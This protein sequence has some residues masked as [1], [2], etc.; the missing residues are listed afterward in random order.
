MT[1][2]KMFTGV[3][4]I[5]ILLIA[6]SCSNSKNVGLSQPDDQR[7]ATGISVDSFEI[8]RYNA[9]GFEDASLNP[10]ID[11]YIEQVG[12]ETALVI[13]VDEQDVDRTIAL[14]VEFDGI[15]MHYSR[16]EFHGLLGGDD[17]V[18]GAS[19]GLTD[20]VQLGQTA[21]RDYDPG[22]ISG[23][24]ATIYFAPG[25]SRNTSAVIGDVYKS[26]T[27]VEVNRCGT[28]PNFV[29]DE[30]TEN[31][32][33]FTNAW[34]MAD[35]DQNGQ[36]TI[37]DITPIG[38]YLN[39]SCESNPLA[40]RADY[41]NNGTVTI[42]ELTPLGV[43][44]NEGVSGYRVGLR[45]DGSGST[46]L[47][48]EKTLDPSADAIAA[49]GTPAVADL[50][51]IF[52]H[53]NV[54]SIFTAGEISAADVNGTNGVEICVV[55]GNTNGDGTL[56]F[57]PWGG[58]D[59]PTGNEIVISSFDIQ[60][61]GVTGG[62]G[63]PDDIFDNG[64]AG[65]SVTANA[66][67]SFQLNSISGTF[68]GLAFTPT[69]LADGMTQGHYD[70]ALAAVRDNTAWTFGTAGA[71]GFRSTSEW[72]HDGAGGVIGGTGD[73]GAGTVFPDYDP[74]SDEFSPEGTLNTFLGNNASLANGTLGGNN[75]V[76]KVLSDRDYSWT[77]D[78]VRDPQQAT[79]G[80]I[81]KQGFDPQ[82]EY[83]L[84]IGTRSFFFT[85]D[86]GELGQPANFDSIEM[87]IYQVVGRNCTLVN[88]FSFTEGT[89]ATGE[90]GI[91]ENS[92]NPGEFVFEYVVNGANLQGSS[93]YVVRWFNGVAWTSINMPENKTI[94][95]GPAPAAADLTSIPNSGGYKGSDQTEFLQILYPNPK[96]RRWSDVVPNPETEA[97]DIEKGVDNDGF[98]VDKTLA[99]N[100]ILRTDGDEFAIFVTPIDSPQ[101]FKIWPQ[102][103]IKNFTAT[104]ETDV[105][106]ADIPFATPSGPVYWSEPGA[107]SAIILVQ[108]GLGRIVVDIKGLPTEG[109]DFSSINY[110][111][112][113]FS[114]QGSDF[115]EVG[116]GTFTMS[117]FD[118][119]V[120][121]NAINWGIDAFDRE[122]RD[123]DNG[124]WSNH[125]VNGNFVNDPVQP[126]VM[127]VEFNG[128]TVYDWVQ[129]E[130]KVH[131]VNTSLDNIYIQVKDVD[132]PADTRIMEVGLRLIGVTPTGTFL[133]I[134]T[135]TNRDFVKIP[136]PPPS[137]TWGILAPG[138]SYEVSI[139]DRVQGSD[140]F[141]TDAG[142]LLVVI[143]TNPNS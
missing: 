46:T 24:F 123:L 32:A 9:A 89:P 99:F 15:N 93:N 101:G 1:L 40:T 127:W 135:I 60:M 108:H 52:R 28:N 18:L 94:P 78:V 23:R 67:V 65:G 84:V 90:F 54:A 2:R 86:W 55:P 124:N 91:R 8:T 141:G 45:D 81:L 115:L 128:G 106:S 68:D 139:N 102:V 129:N 21:I 69:T 42:S 138:H 33:W 120:A 47:S 66:S 95:S 17:D 50:R 121:P 19:F 118:D 6:A 4:C 77:I 62:N 97:V 133:A 43:H 27:G 29:A 110:G 122:A 109:P 82:D 140:S 53:Y 12:S 57:V 126:F 14:N 64:I 49:T 36:C 143:G 104:M 100:D 125:I 51:T 76:V 13:N 63:T 48:A 16:T 61:V 136:A 111:F 59:G 30:V 20:S 85:A 80:P 137:E 31:E 87:E 25:A 34:M 7:N 35:G 98:A 11:A 79:F 22:S 44:L 70:A 38:I 114:P 119:T 72:V 92:E 105:T 117:P 112:G 132:Q 116:E 107:A 75:Y 73:P 130:E 113:L 39:Q 5:L 3:L 41:D 58:G 134:H 103:L 142:D 56:A 96:I 10:S 74:E 71:A 131:K 26:S 83:A 88:D 37:A